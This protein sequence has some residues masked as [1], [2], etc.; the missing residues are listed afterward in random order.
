MCHDCMGLSVA[1]HEGVTD[2]EWLVF[3]ASVYFIPLGSSREVHLPG[4]N[5]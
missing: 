1:G 2:Q 5:F 4:S 3:H